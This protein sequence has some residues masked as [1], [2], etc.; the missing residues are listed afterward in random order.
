MKSKN[1]PEYLLLKKAIKYAVDHL[2]LRNIVVY[3]VCANIDFVK[4]TFAYAT[5]KGINV[6]Y[7][8]NELFQR[9]CKR[10]SKP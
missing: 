3:N 7:P 5:K 1:S 4:E 2:N 8:N 9:N 6:I 10:L